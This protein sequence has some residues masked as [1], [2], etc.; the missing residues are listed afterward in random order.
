MSFWGDSGGFFEENSDEES[1][2]DSNPVSSLNHGRDSVIFLIDATESMVENSIDGATLFQTCFKCL[3]SVLLSKIISRE[4]D[5][6]GVVLF[7]TNVKKNESDFDNIYE[8]QSL[9][10]PEANQILKVE[11]LLSEKPIKEFIKHL[12]HSNSFSISEA[13]WACSS[14]FAN[15][16]YKLGKKTI[17]LFT[18]TDDPHS[19]NLNLKKQA[20]KRGRDLSDLGI[21]LQLMHL[22]KENHHFDV[23][24]FYKDLINTED[25]NTLIDPSEKF[26]ELLTRVRIKSHNK[27]TVC[28]LLFFFN[29][30]IKFGVSM[31]ILNKLCTKGSHV[32]IDRRTNEEVQCSTKYFCKDTGL[33]LLSTDIKCYQNF[34]GEKVIF[35]KE[36]VDKMKAFIE[37]GFHL[38]G[39]KKIKYL[40][41][42]YHIKPSSFIYPDENSYLGSSNIFATL[43]KRCVV[44]KV[45]PICVLVSSTF[46]CP[47][48]V[49][50]MPQTELDDKKSA[51]VNAPGFH[52]IYLPYSEDIRK[53]KLE[54]RS[55]ANDDQVDKAKK[56]IEKLNIDYSISMFENPSIQKFYRC[57]EAYALDREEMDEFIDST[58]PKVDY[59]EKDAS[60]EIQEF[61]EIV[62]PEDYNTNKRGNSSTSESVSKKVKCD[63]TSEVDIEAVARNGLLNKLTVSQMKIFCQK[64][65]IKSS[66]FKK[67]DFVSAINS[68]YK[69]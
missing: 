47:R 29:D 37:P 39:F 18:T 9:D 27:R 57:L 60:K 31:Y 67:A 68:F 24:A 48:F 33:E 62:F 22:K 21:D 28:R 69:I 26:E 53:L 32:N 56:L 64:N 42:F 61:K 23:S 65:K 40:K 7:G 59:M 14:M 30:S 43:L 50:L 44:K 38:L 4:K 17:L 3:H 13:L 46:S 6:I 15:S 2:S 55:R 10:M 12:G 49:A 1:F 54:N 11:N 52:V 35:E 5:L 20:L 58:L 34:G 16:S 45:L 25:Y 8:Y 19:N 51:Q 63:E 66:S 41:D 36:E